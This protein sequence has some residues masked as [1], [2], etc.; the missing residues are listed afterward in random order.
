MPEKIEGNIRVHKLRAILLMEAEF[1]QMNKLFFGHRMIK[2]SEEFKRIPDEAY[3][4]RAS[5][6]AIPVAVN[7][8]LVI[9]LFKQKCR[10]GSI[11]D[12]DAA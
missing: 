6:N 10:C 5:L 11:A 3:E 12:V 2:Q 7:I 4:S 1:N 9:D 8:R